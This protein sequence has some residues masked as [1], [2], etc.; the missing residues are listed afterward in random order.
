MMYT[1]SQSDS[2]WRCKSQISK[3]AQKGQGSQVNWS[4]VIL[5]LL[6][7]SRA[8]PQLPGSSRSIA[9]TRQGG[10]SSYKCQRDLMAAQMAGGERIQSDG[11]FDCFGRRSEDRLHRASNADVSKLSVCG[12]VGKHMTTKFPNL[13]SLGVCWRGAGQL[14]KDL[15]QY[16]SIDSRTHRS[17]GL[18]T[19]GS[20]YYIG[21]LAQMLRHT[22][23]QWT[24]LGLQAIAKAG[25]LCSYR[26]WIVTDSGRVYLQLINYTMIQ[27]DSSGSTMDYSPF[28]VYGSTHSNEHATQIQ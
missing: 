8:R 19:L 14:H 28:M 23:R 1:R 21:G 17:I 3:P 13:I 6:F 10:S 26:K 5:Q 11:L 24:C 16:H 12:L 2:S 4:H 20:I 27:I 9:S 7:T 18:S 25:P 22:Q 15:E